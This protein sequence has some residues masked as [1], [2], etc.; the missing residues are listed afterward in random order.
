MTRTV[1][2]VISGLG[3]GGAEAI[4]FRLCKADASCKHQVISLMDDGK[5]GAALREAGV[6]VDCLHMPRGRVTFGGLSRLYKLLRSQQ[7][8]V[9]QTWMYHA[10]LVGGVVGRLARARQV[11]WGIHNSK[12]DPAT[13]KQSTIW[14]CRVNALLSRWIPTRIV[15]CARQ[16][17]DVHMRLGFHAPKMLVIANGYDLSRFSPSAAERARVRS[18]LRLA[19]QIPVLGLVARFDPAKDHRNLI[20]SLRILGNRGIDFRMLLVGVG[21][22]A[23][24]SELARWLAEAGVQDRVLL[25]GQRSD[26]PAIMN[27]IDIHVLSSNTEAFPNVLAEAMA[28]GTPC[29]TTDVGDAASIVGDTGWIVPPEDPQALAEALANAI[30]EKNTSEGEWE[31]RRRAARSRVEE[32]FG[33]DRMVAEYH[34]VWFARVG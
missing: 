18:E 8:D 31:A 26:V 25:L 32:R 12:L 10:D 14:V 28:C 2:H 22:T 30:A 20:Q 23:E 17:L 33:L 4:L 9:I 16:A 27:A 5:Y 24:N 7:P 15:C 3:D 29:V 1:T 6:G 19:D 34:R 21:L 13:A 11:F